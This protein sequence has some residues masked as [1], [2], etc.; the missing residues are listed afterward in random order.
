MRI[1][2][3]SQDVKIYCSLSAFNAP[4]CP[5]T[6]W[7]HSLPLSTPGRSHCGHHTV[8]NKQIRDLPETL[9]PHFG[10]LRSPESTRGSSAVTAEHLDTGELQMYFFGINVSKFRVWRQLCNAFVS[11]QV[12]MWWDPAEQLQAGSWRC[13]KPQHHWVLG[14]LFFIS[15]LSGNIRTL[16]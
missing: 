10:T 7:A 12:R 3:R 13:L 15:V 4:L 1:L 6:D 11:H 5:L 14:G 16:K 9:A 2:I 8:I